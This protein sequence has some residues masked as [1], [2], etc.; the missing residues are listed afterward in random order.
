[1]AELERLHKI[2]VTF[3]DD[4]SYHDPTTEE[5]WAFGSGQND[6]S[7]ITQNVDNL[8]KRAGAFH[9]TELHGRTSRLKCMNCGAF[10]SRDDFH[11]ELESLNETWL[12]EVLSEKQEGDQRPDGDGFVPRSDYHDVSVPPCNVCGGFLKPD[13]V[14]FGDSVPRHRVERSRAALDASDG[15][16]C[17]GTSLAVHSAFRFVRAAQKKGIP[18]AILNVGETRAEAEGI[19]VLKV[20]AP[21]GSTLTACVE[22]LTIDSIPFM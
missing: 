3:R 6:V 11:A 18:I 12:A 14:F 13:V 15:L 16:L 2:G 7:I 17:I 8:H 19:E 10:R 1:M 21:I 4:P 20:E 9:V 22:Q 5:R